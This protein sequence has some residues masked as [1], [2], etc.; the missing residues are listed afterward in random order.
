MT[1]S[2]T[3]SLMTSLFATAVRPPRRRDARRSLGAA[4]LITSA[5]I[6]LTGCSATGAAEPADPSSSPASSPA[7]ALIDTY[8]LSGA[9]F[10]PAVARALPDGTPFGGISGLEPL[11]DD[12]YLGIS[13][14]RADKGPARVYRLALP[15]TP[16]GGTGLAQVTGM[17]LLTDEHGRGFAPGSVDP[18]SIRAMPDG[19]LLWTSEGD[20]EAGI[21]PEITVAA[22][23]GR[24]LR[25]FAIPGYQRPADDGARG[26]RP[27]KA[28]EGLTLFDGGARAAVLAEGPLA[29][30]PNAP[31]ASRTRLTVYDVASGAAAAEYAYPLDAP[32]DGTDERGATE[33]LATGDGRFLVLERSWIKGQGTVGKLYL[34]DTAGADDVLGAA[35]LTGSETPVHKTLLLDFSPNGENVDNIESLAWAPDQA[36]GRQTL[37]VGSDDNFNTGE[38]RSLI[39]T[40]VVA[41]PE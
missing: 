9:Q 1:D 17:I 41:L 24:A 37:L 29:Q 11:G 25:R 34:V 31:G 20:A 26:V 3:S 40:V 10:S 13:D 22:E 12:R 7:A 18:E 14:D 27:N 36:D 30:D 15:R 5:L 6:A 33:I 28:Y 38:Q 8:D 39:H 4:A 23:D 32:P 16:D 19:T 21:A 35:V 2:V